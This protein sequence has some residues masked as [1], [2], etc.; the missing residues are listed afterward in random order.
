MS[1]GGLARALTTLL[2]DT[3][4]SLLSQEEWDALEELESQVFRT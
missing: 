4:P 1:V 2:D 3:P